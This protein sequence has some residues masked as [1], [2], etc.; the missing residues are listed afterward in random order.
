MENMKNGK[1]LYRKMNLED[2]LNDCADEMAQDNELQEQCYAIAGWLIK[3]GK[4][5]TSNAVTLADAGYSAYDIRRLV[6]NVSN[7]FGDGFAL[8]SDHFNFIFTNVNGL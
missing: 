1:M 7:Y 2:W 5:C 4:N 6:Y 3:Y 8:L